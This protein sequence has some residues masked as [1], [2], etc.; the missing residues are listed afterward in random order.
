MA[1]LTSWRQR[2]SAGFVARLC[3]EGAVT[4]QP[5]PAQ[6][7]VPGTR[8]GLPVGGPGR[9][10]RDA[11]SARTLS[12]TFI[13]PKALAFAAS[14][15]PD[16][17]ATTCKISTIELL[18]RCQPFVLTLGSAAAGDLS[19]PLSLSGRHCAGGSQVPVDNSPI[20][21]SIIAWSSTRVPH[22][23]LHAR[24]V[25]PPWTLFQWGSSHSFGT[26]ESPHILGKSTGRHREPLYNN[27]RAR[28]TSRT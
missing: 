13:S 18:N 8:S 12:E 26:S 25:K 2:P 24:L 10:S 22:Q 3:A 7:A 4:N 9:S 6:K 16:N 11:S 23:Y 19:P 5:R 1:C 17:D 20:L 27:Q 28:K 21:G 14:L 15:R